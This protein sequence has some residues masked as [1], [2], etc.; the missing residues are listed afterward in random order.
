MRWWRREDGQSST[1]YAGFLAAI[2]FVFVAV[3]ALGLDGRVSGSV[4]QAVCEITGGYDCTTPAPRPHEYPAKDSDRAD[5][6]VYDSKCEQDFPGDVVREGNEG[7]SGNAEADAA[8]ENLGTVFDYYWR[9]FGR[10]SFDGEGGPLI[11]SINLCDEDGN[12]V[13]NA[14]WD[15]TQMKF[16]PGYAAPLDITAHELTHA[17]TERTAGL[18][19]S[20]QSG[21]L[22]E[23]LSDI[24]AYNV[25]PTNTTIGE[26]LPGGAIRDFA[27]PSEGDPPQPAHV[28]DFVEIEND[29]TEHSDYGGVHYNSGIPNHAYYL[30]VQAIGR[31]HAEQIVYEAM[32]NDL[33]SDSN[34]E[35]FRAAMLK[36][37][38]DLYGAGSTD[39]KGVDDSFAAVGLDGKWQAPEIK[40]C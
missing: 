25:D 30:L 9:T 35:D 17:V 39:V 10:D 23:S 24:M 29:G 7:P 21:A 4:R 37:A 6:H 3:F 31:D 12:P 34:F 33:D 20:C 40:G 28:D 32:T 8:Y 27:D 5:R 19:Y 16:G 2:G 11:A 14:Y 1:D 26:D 36:A 15:G 22:N 18:D 38:A 13:A